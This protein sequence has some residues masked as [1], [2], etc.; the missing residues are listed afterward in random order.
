MLPEYLC[1]ETFSYKHLFHSQLIEISHKILTFL[2]TA[3]FLD[4]LG[5]KAW[6]QPDVT[7]IFDAGA[8]NYILTLM[9]AAMNQL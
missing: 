5:Y 1:P 8:I 7:D 6:I 9:P 3:Y 2:S 4:D